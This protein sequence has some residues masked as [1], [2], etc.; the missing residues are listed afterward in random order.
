M[1]MTVMAM[2]TDKF[3]TAQGL[4]HSANEPIIKNKT[5][6]KQTLPISLNMSRF[7]SDST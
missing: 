7:D 4:W 2:I 3:M 1:T 6:F 5:T